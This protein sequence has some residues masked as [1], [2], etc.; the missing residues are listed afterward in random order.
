MST[1]LCSSLSTHALLKPVNLQICRYQKFNNLKRRNNNLKTL[2]SVGGQ[3]A[4]SES[5][6]S[7][8]RNDG[9]LERFAQTTVQFLRQRNFDGL[10][11]DWEYPNATTKE[12]F[13]KLLKVLEHGQISKYIYTINTK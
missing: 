11:I 13:T 12:S 4:G 1:S 7:V 5:F 3:L 6:M 9:I 2:L 8:T 10:D